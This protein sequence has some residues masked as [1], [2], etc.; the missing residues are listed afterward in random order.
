MAQAGVEVEDVWVKLE[1]KFRNMDHKLKLKLNLR[2]WLK[3]KLKF[4]EDGSS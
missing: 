2:R 1:L 4:E 3:L